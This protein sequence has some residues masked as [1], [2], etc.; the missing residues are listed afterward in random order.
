M[1]SRKGPPTPGI[2]RRRVRE[3]APCVTP[4]LDTPRVISTPIDA[5]QA[6]RDFIGSRASECFVVLYLSIR[7]QAVG[8]LLLTEGNPVGVGVHPQGLFQEGLLV[9]GSGFITAHQHPSGNSSP[10]NDDFALWKRLREAGVIMGMPCVDNFVI[11]PT[12]YY[13]ESLGSSAAY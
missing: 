11:T 10:S 9:N 5:V 6:I 2:A 8:Y 4:F 3:V 13:S 1:A 12:H 7:N